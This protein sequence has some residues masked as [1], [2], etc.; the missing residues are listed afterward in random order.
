[1]VFVRMCRG[2]LRPGDVVLN[3]HT[4]ETERASRLYEVHADRH[5]ERFVLEAGDIAGGSPKK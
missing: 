3:T 2:R 1:M 4:G 5:E